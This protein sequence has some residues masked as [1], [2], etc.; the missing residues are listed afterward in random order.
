MA[1]TGWAAELPFCVRLHAG[2]IHGGVSCGPVRAWCSVSLC[3]AAGAAPCWAGGC[4]AGLFSLCLLLSSAEYDRARISV[5][6]LDVG[7]G[8]C[9]YVE[10]AGVSAMYDCGGEGDP[11]T[12]AAL[13]LQNLGRPG[14][15]ILVLSHYDE[16]HAGGAAA[17]LD[18][19]AGGDAVPAGAGR[20]FRRA[21]GDPGC[22][23]A[24]RLPGVFRHIRSAPD[25][26]KRGSAA[27]CPGGKRLWATTPA[28]PPIGAAAGSPC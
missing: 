5:T 22:G 12:T 24:E 4:L 15:D 27:L 10:S 6:M 17:L 23:G 7:Q 16:D 20:W 25:A 28:W 9:V 1:V 26:G 18:A 19:G 8:Q 2:R 11:A 14:L 3:R 13:F 21:G